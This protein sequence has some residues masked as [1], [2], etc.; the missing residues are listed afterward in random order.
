MGEITVYIND[1]D[2]QPALPA[3]DGTA[4]TQDLDVTVQEKE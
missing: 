1:T 3:T 2:F 4:I